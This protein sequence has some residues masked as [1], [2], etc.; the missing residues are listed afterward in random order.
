MKKLITISLTLL[1][2]TGCGNK[3]TC[4]TNK[5]DIRETYKIK[6]NNNTNSSLQAEKD[7]KIYLPF[8]REK[9]I[10]FKSNFN[11]LKSKLQTPKNFFK[12]TYN[13][14]EIYMNFSGK[15]INKPSFN[16]NIKSLI[17]SIPTDEISKNLDDY[18]R[19]NT[20]RQNVVKFNRLNITT[21]YLKSQKNLSITNNKI[22]QK[23]LSNQTDIQKSNASLFKDQ[24][25]QQSI[26]Y[27]K[28]KNIQM[29]DNSIKYNNDEFI[30]GNT[31]QK[32]KKNMIRNYDEK[33]M[34]E[35]LYNIDNKII[36]KDNN[37][38]YNLNIIN[39]NNNIQYSKININH[40][41]P[42]KLSLPVSFKDHTRLSNILKSPLVNHFRK[43]ED[44]KD[45]N[46]SDTNN[47]IKLFLVL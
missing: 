2:L 14:D 13:L 16:N 5:D 36:L 12:K 22:E 11:N 1:L 37:S 8:T 44:N 23:N 18:N 39:N 41:N 7:K 43:I 27:R 10:S 6:Y 40:D 35:K 28:I 17:N 24:L 9:R 20:D 29:K 25:S 15:N 46:N 33:V 32:P 30:H 4:K 38:K 31:E 21:N 26:K 19:S 42:R 47:I 34:N 3:I 45:N